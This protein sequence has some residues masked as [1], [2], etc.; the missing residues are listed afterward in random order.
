MNTANRVNLIGSSCSDVTEPPLLMDTNNGAMEQ[1]DWSS[2]AKE[3]LPLMDSGNYQ[4]DE[5]DWP[6]DV[7]DTLSLVGSTNRAI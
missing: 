5:S 7:I 2:N 4:M 3:T 6:S 1:S